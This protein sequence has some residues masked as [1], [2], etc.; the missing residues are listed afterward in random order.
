MDREMMERFYGIEEWFF[1]RICTFRWMSDSLE[2]LFEPTLL[3][4]SCYT[5]L[6]FHRDELTH[7][8]L[9]FVDVMLMQAPFGWGGGVS[10]IHAAI[11]LVIGRHGE[12]SVGRNAFW[13]QDQI[14]S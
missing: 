2:R 9:D 11:H 7:H 1:E 8:G 6:Y 12:L 3:C 10:L 4:V 5:I 13:K 14:L